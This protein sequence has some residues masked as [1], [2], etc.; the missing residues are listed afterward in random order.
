MIP[1]TDFPLPEIALQVCWDGERWVI[2]LP[3][4]Y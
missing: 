1:Y 3:G 2:V 4:E